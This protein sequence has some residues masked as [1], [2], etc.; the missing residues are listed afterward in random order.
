MAKF[1]SGTKVAGDSGQK[2]FEQRQ[3]AFEVWRQL[4]QQRPQFSGLV[5]RLEGGDELRGGR[6]CAAEALEVRD[7]LVRL[8]GE[9]EIGRGGL[10]PVLQEILCGE[11]A[12]SV[13]DLD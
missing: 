12:E 6:D 10:K 2:F 4:K 9:Q 3:I 5:Q 13:V 11:N 7:P 8:D 1:K